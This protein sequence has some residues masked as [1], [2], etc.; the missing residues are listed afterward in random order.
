MGS[1]RRLTNGDMG[2]SIRPARFGPLNASAFD[3]G[4]RCGA[5]IVLVGDIARNRRADIE[6]AG[7]DR[8]VSEGKPAWLPVANNLRSRRDTARRD[9]HQG[10][11]AVDARANRPAAG[12]DVLL[13]DTSM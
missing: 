1:R 5:E 8:L 12:L 6:T 2:A 4:A 11:F 10:A 13:V 3:R 9:D 7:A